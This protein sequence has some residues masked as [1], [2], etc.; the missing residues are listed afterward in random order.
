MWIL[1]GGYVLDSGLKTSDQSL[2]S[3]GVISLATSIF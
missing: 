1:D 2:V 3:D